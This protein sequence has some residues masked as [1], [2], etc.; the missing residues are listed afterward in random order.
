MTLLQIKHWKKIKEWKPAHLFR[1]CAKAEE[2]Q[3][4]T[5]NLRA[6]IKSSIKAGQRNKVHK[7]KEDRM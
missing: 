7:V 5:A 3:E 4:F 1:A 6:A 2:P